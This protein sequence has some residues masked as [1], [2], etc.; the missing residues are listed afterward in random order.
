MLIYKAEVKMIF[1]IQRSGIWLI[2][3]TAEYPMVRVFVNF[4]NPAPEIG[5]VELLENC[6]PH[7]LIEALEEINICLKEYSLLLYN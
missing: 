1:E 4:R 5:K 3:E 2:L 7:D 6:S